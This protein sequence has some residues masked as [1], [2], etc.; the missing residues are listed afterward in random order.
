N[1]IS[2]LK[3]YKNYYVSARIPLLSPPKAVTASPRGKPCGF[4]ASAL[5]DNLG[6]LRRWDEKGGYSQN[7]HK[8]TL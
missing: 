3:R 8:Y 2:G 5:N 1:A 7:V 6:T 4:A